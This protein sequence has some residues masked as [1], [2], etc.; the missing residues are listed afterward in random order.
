M[1][2]LVQ[3]AV[4]YAQKGLSVIPMIRKKPMITFADQPPLT[5]DEI[6]EFWQ[7]H[8]YANI[9]LRTDQFFVFDV[10]VHQGGANGIQS[11]KELNHPE[12]F[13]DTLVQQT[14]HGGYQYFFL[15]PDGAT[16]T[17]H[18]GILPGIDLKA[19][20]NN[21][22]MVAPSVVDGKRYRWLNQKPI[23]QAPTGLMELI[24]KKSRPVYNGEINQE[25]TVTERTKTAELF[26]EII[27]GLGATGGRNNA[28]AEFCG[29]L[30]FRGVDPKVTYELA[31]IA[32]DNTPTPLPA[33]E[34]TATVNS[35]IKKE[36]RRREA[37]ENN[38]TG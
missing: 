10:D 17:Q 19:H 5:V 32:N 18:I 26:E 11:F 13:K 2:N 25:Y 38:Q 6:Q 27:H 33:Q 9:A 12:W 35:M 8:P 24:H 34:V 29:G 1:Q 7:T 37:V 20:H 14:P 21:Y 28:L 16:M 22:V 15:K 4:R 30:L 31:K 23:K 36:V 3:Y